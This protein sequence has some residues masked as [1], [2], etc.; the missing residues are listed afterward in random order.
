MLISTYCNKAS[1]VEW[2]RKYEIWHPDEE[3]TITTIDTSL[4]K[5]YETP[6]FNAQSMIYE[7]Q[8]PLKRGF[9]REDF[10]NEFLVLHHIRADCIVRQETFLAE[11]EFGDPFCGL[12][13]DTPDPEANDFYAMV[14]SGHPLYM[15]PIHRDELPSVRAAY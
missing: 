14:P 2:A 9:Q 8:L 5:K 11:E 7:M 1:A 12:R 4:L 6:V 15:K 10:V 13:S 3:I